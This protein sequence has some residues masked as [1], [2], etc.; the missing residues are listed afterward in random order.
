MAAYT[1]RLGRLSFVTIRDGLK[2]ATGDGLDAVGAVLTGAEAKPRAFDLTLPIHGA[3][4]LRD[5]QEQGMRQRRQV[6]ALMENPLA[7]L[8]G[9]YLALDFDPELN[10]WL[11][12]GGGDLTYTDG[13]VTFA[14]FELALTDCYKVA[15]LRT[16][17]PARRVALYDRR[18]T[19][20][21]I[22]TLRRRYGGAFPS[23]GTLP[24]VYLPYGARDVLG[25]GRR[26][27][28]GAG[29]V[30]SRD[31][32]VLVVSDAASSEVLSYERDES[33]FRKGDVVVYERNGVGGLVAAGHSFVAGFGLPAP[34]SDNYA[35]TYANSVVPSAPIPYRNIAANGSV[36]CWDQDTTTHAAGNGYAKYLQTIKRPTWPTLGDLPLGDRNLHL[37]NWALNDL[38]IL[39]YLNPTPM[40]E[41]HRTVV[42]R[43]RQSVFC[44]HT[45]A[46]IAYGTGWTTVTATNFNSGPGYRTCN[47]N[48]RTVTL[49]IPAIYQGDPLDIL[50]IVKST[51]AATITVAITGAT[52]RTDTH[53][54]DAASQ[55]NVA[56]GAYNGVTRR[57]TGLNPGAHT[58][59]LTF[60]GVTGTPGFNGYGVEAVKP[61]K[62]LVTGAVR[63]PNYYF[64]LFASVPYQPTDDSFPPWNAALAALVA[65]FDTQVVLLDMDQVTNKNPD[66]VQSDG[67][68]P[69]PAGVQVYAAEVARYASP[70]EVMGP[71]QPV[72]QVDV[73]SLENGRCRVRF[74]TTGGT[75]P[76]GTASINI[77]FS[78]DTWAGTGWLEAGKIV[79]TR[80]FVRLCTLVSSQVVEVTPERAVVK[81]VLA[82]GSLDVA[83]R[84]EVYLT[85]ERGWAGPRVE[86]Y[87]SPLAGGGA[88]TPALGWAH[89]N[90]DVTDAMM[91]IGAGGAAMASTAPGGS[92]I[93]TNNLGNLDGEGLVTTH[94]LGFNAVHPQM[95]VCQTGVACS[96][97]SDVDAF[98]NSAY[99]AA[100]SLTTLVVTDTYLGVRYGFQPLLTDLLMD[101]ESMT[102]GAGTTN[103]AVAGSNGGN[104]AR[105]TR[106]SDANAHVTRANWPGGRM[107]RYRIFARVKT[108][109]STLNLYAKTTGTG[110]TTGATKTTT[111]TSYIW[112]DL[113]EVQ[114]GVTT[115]TLEIHAWASAAATFDVDMVQAYKM[116]DR[117]AAPASFDGARDL[118]A[119]ELLT[120]TVTPEL[121]AR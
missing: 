83:S 92:P 54:L 45:D 58:I 109:A 37:F 90:A 106:T 67:C 63:Q 28:S 61:P 30:P 21:A 10:G 14:D 8:Q 23:L 107:G 101:A 17:R 110:G 72:S 50:Y 117:T 121:V 71:D 69:S 24:L 27:I 82:V 86:W 53:I 35:A 76:L 51:D 36:C 49:T 91:K 112:L 88:P 42:C 65:E 97:G 25:T 84:E 57:L 29:Q 11:L 94:R 1:A 52:T 48:G 74:D 43:A 38:S 93:G 87:A 119:S 70:D 68:H 98:G 62:V 80:G 102:L 9:L 104:A 13:G 99:G 16:H 66:L 114:V 31:G 22:D 6:R 59:T 32:N 81:A 89:A 4:H 103:T 18:L 108:S 5:W 113:G 40:V 39:G 12:I 79:F 85:L 46:S 105:G 15:S 2:E 95:A 41:A 56:Y 116:E 3:D 115:S 75:T 33:D 7:R 120:R 26:V 77:G 96:V 73:P 47:A 60:N 34:A 100:V 78:V 44:E 55:A 19:S 20:T 111:S 64:Q 118:A